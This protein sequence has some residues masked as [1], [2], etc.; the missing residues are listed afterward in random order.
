MVQ[1]ILQSGTSFCYYKRGQLL[2][3]NG[4]S[5][6]VT[7]W[8]NFITKWDNFITKWSITGFHHNK[9]KL[10]QNDVNTKR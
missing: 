5:S 4:T 2:L 7:K 1:E 3:Q 9:L 10:Q 6:F 8:D